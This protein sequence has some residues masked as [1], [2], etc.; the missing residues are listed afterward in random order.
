MGWLAVIITLYGSYLVGEKCKRGFVCQIVGNLLW[1][2]VGI[3]RGMQW[4]LI[5]VSLAFVV[6]YVINLRKWWRAE[7]LEIKPNLRIHNPS[8]I[9]L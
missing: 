8:K 2:A 9:I 7:R 6:L 1:A 5:A 4:D 3:T